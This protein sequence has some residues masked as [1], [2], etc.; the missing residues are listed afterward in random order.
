MIGSKTSKLSRTLEYAYKRVDRQS[1]T[2]YKI[3]FLFNEMPFVSLPQI[4]SM[5]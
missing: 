5:L 1:A 2:P 4:L 3:L